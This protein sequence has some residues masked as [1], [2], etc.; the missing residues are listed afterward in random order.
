[1]YWLSTQ[2]LNGILFSPDAFVVV[3]VVVVFLQGLL[4]FSTDGSFITVA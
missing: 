1:M 3:V 4:T 2:E